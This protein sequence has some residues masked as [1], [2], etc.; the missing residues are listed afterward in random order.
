VAGP[1]TNLSDIAQTLNF[2]RFDGSIETA[3][4]EL[5]KAVV[6][7]TRDGPIAK[8]SAGVQRPGVQVH[9]AADAGHR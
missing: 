2:L 3:D 5:A 1:H 7:P 9:C 6:S 4:P 8:G